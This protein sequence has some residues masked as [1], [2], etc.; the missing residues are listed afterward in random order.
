MGLV[1]SGSSLLHSQNGLEGGV[2]ILGWAAGCLVPVAWV[3]PFPSQTQLACICWRLKLRRSGSVWRQC[4]A[5]AGALVR[6]ALISLA[7]VYLPL[8]WSNYVPG[9]PSVFF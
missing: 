3:L 2:G 5:L 9:S 4:S 6:K 8:E 7:S 1:P